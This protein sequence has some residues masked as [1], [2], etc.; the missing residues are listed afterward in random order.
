MDAPF[1]G[2]VSGGP[3]EWAEESALRRVR[4][5]VE[6][7]LFTGRQDEQTTVLD[8]H[9]NRTISVDRRMSGERDRS[10]EGASGL[11]A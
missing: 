8:M 5:P 6:L 7:Q 11:Q 1:R 9:S 2:G 4:R 10:R 3:V